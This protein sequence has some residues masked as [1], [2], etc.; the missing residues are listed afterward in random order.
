MRPDLLHLSPQA[1]AQ[2]TN[3]G[4]VKRA[5]REREA[6]Y[7][8]TLSLE[9][10]ATLVAA[11][12]DGVITRWPAGKPIGQ[13]HC[14]CIAAGICR[15]RLIAV[16]QFCAEANATQAP[17]VM[18]GAPEKIA[19]PDPGSP[20]EASDETLAALLPAS[21]LEQAKKERD[22]GLA[23]HIRRR[24]AGEP[25][26]TARLPAATVR[27]WAGAAIEA[28]R[29][30]CIRQSACEH[31]ALGVWA[32]RQA[33]SETPAAS[34]EVRLGA[35]ASAIRLD[36][37]PDL[38]YLTALLRHGVV[39]GATGS[40]QAASLARAA[41]L[42]AR[43]E[44][45]IQTLADLETW[46]MA[47]SQRSARYAAETG[48]DLMA[49]LLLRLKLGAAPGQ[50]KA[51][52]GI[53]QPRE[54]TLDRLR[55]FCLGARTERDG[56]ARRTRLALADQDT[57]T[58]M[59][60]VHD[61]RV[62]AP[63][64]STATP[65]EAVQREDWQRASERAAPG[66]KLAQLVTSQ[67]L[68]QQARRFADGRIVLA[69]ARSTQNSLLPQSGDWEGLARPVRFTQVADLIGERPRHPL[70]R[71]RQA[72]GPFIVFSPATIT[73]ALY[74]PHLQ[75]VQCTAL[76][77]GGAPLLISRSHA[78]HTR[79]A[80]ETFAAAVS[81]RH[82]ALR[83]ISGLLSWQGDLPTLEPWSIVCD[84]VMSLDFGTT[85]P[86]AAEALAALPLG[87][88]STA[89]DDPLMA[90]LCEIKTL[91]ATLL[92]HGIDALPLVWPADSRA[93]AARLRN[94]GWP[95]LAQALAAL[96]DAVL[97]QHTPDH[98]RQLTRAF[99]TL[100]TLRQLHEDALAH[101]QPDQ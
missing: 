31:V 84:Q 77:T 73:G 14:S 71:T 15:H 29:C 52:L 58:L 46:S 34:T 66:V 41:A 27:F 56:D 30:D 22:A 18:A 42:A 90:A 74:D 53:G 75:T 50:A 12:P 68:C 38:D 36:P 91:L 23:V 16:L 89:A 10:D 67:L 33:D 4:L 25:C 11:F 6:G 8:P 63:P 54:V 43:A 20:G 97:E 98:A 93:A 69:R 83:H 59:A 96:T 47:Y 78:A 26:D 32:F 7:T 61:W 40:A 80:L 55:L 24:A 65:Q 60:L 2:H 37:A 13:A 28:A 57:G 72:A 3:A 9:A 99:C 79:Q 51:I 94:L 17:D 101:A 86:G 48:V 1:L 95:A 88:A 5:M 64:T 70:T 49:E 62:P 87:R 21:T 82:G 39:T 35:A 44:W 76:D 85:I 100:L 81:G 92:H 19:A 45:I